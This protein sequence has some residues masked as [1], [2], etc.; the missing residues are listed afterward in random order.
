MFVWLCCVFCS[1][2]LGGRYAERVSVE[3]RE[4]TGAVAEVLCRRCKRVNY[5]VLR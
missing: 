2:K 1:H 5:L 4:R 3:D